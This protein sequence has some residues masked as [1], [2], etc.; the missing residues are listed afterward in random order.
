MYVN[1]K[2]EKEQRWNVYAEHSEDKIS[3]F[4][5]EKMVSDCCCLK[6]PNHN[7]SSEQEYIVGFSSPDFPKTGLEGFWIYLLKK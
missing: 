5:P 7:S 6:L 2:D 4:T 3:V 1:N